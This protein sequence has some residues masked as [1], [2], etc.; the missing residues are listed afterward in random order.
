MGLGA[1]GV[2]EKAVAAVDGPVERG[3]GAVERGERDEFFAFARAVLAKRLPEKNPGQDLDPLFDELVRVAQVTGVAAVAEVKRDGG[4]RIEEL[5]DTDDHI[6]GALLF[7]V[8]LE[9][10]FHVVSGAGDAGE[11]RG[12]FAVEISERVDRPA[13]GNVVAL[14]GVAKT[15]GEVDAGKLAREVAGPGLAPI[16]EPGEA[17]L[18]AAGGRRFAGGRGAGDRVDRAGEAGAIIDPKR[19]LDERGLRLDHHASAGL[20]V[21]GVFI[22]DGAFGHSA[23]GCEHRKG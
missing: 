13:V 17:D 9:E 10:H 21:V 23:S 15:E 22:S 12:V 4:A 18:I 8:G 11:E 3:K 2:V 7:A 14:A 16:A 1:E 5:G 6:V 19:L 20:T